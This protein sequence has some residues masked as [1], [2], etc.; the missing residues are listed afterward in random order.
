VTALGGKSATARP[1]EE[2]AKRIRRARSLTTGPDSVAGV[3]QTSNA[4]SRRNDGWR[5]LRR[6]PGFVPISL[7]AVAA[8]AIRD[9]CANA[10]ELGYQV[11]SGNPEESNSFTSSDWR[12]VPVL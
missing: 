5:M 9:L 12:E 2:Q 1:E 10:D 6:P 11:L 4:Y 8:F 7:V 3:G